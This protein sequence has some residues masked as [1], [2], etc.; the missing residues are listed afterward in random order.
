VLQRIQSV[1]DYLPKEAIQECRALVEDFRKRNLW[2][3]D[4]FYAQ[5][6]FMPRG[7]TISGLFGDCL[8]VKGGREMLEGFENAAWKCH[9]GETT[10]DG[11]YDLERSSALGAAPSHPLWSSLDDKTMPRVGFETAGDS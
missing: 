4:H 5:F 1:Y 11:K 9:P 7:S 2:V 8:H 3:S 10:Q 6:R